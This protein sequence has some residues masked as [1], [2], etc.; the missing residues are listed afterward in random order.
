MMLLKDVYKTRTKD[1]EDK[2]LDITDLATNT[3]LNI[4]INGVINEVPSITNLAT[5]AGLNAKTNEV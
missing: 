3:T 5:T 2:I 1:I 4:K